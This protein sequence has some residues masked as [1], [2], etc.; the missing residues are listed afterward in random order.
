[1]RIELVTLTFV[2]TFH[3]IW[4]FLLLFPVNLVS[5]YYAPLFVHLTSSDLLRKNPNQVLSD[6]V[7]ASL[8]QAVNAF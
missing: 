6:R 3:D 2:K 8:L 5:L 4:Q 1:M 7:H